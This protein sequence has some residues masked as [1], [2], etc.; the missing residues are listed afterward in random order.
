[1]PVKGDAALATPASSPIRPDD[2]IQT[3][4]ATSRDEND[5]LLPKP[6]DEDS[7]NE[8]RETW[9]SQSLGTGFIWI[10]I[11]VVPTLPSPQLSN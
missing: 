6:G 7:Q 11:G 5:A 3:H 10:Q 8:T 2:L 9:S 1:M 4:I